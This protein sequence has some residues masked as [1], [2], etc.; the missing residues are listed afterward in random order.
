MQQI[1]LV[2]KGSNRQTNKD[3]PEYKL[4][5]KQILDFALQVLRFGDFQERWEVTKIFS[6]LGDR[7]VPSLL[8]ILENEGEDLE[9]RWFAIRIL[10]KFDRSEVIISLAKVLRNTEEE[11]LCAIAATALANIGTPAIEVLSELLQMKDRDY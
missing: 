9:S 10:G 1:I 3:N 5:F 7:V 4:E 2:D 6:G 8:D 11:D